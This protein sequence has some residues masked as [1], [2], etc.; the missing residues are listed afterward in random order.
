MKGV[1]M[2][3]MR[4]LVLT[5]VVAVASFASSSSSGVDV[6]KVHLDTTTLLTLAGTIA[7]GLG[8]IWG[9]RKVIKLLN[10]S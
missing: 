4:A 5:G 2:N 8:V 3:G 6:S 1:I 10:R 7:T 9:I